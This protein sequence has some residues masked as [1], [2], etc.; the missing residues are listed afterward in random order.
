METQMETKNVRIKIAG[1]DDNCRIAAAYASW[2]YGGGITPEDTA[3]FA[4]ISGDVIGT[5][6]VAPEHGTLVLRGMQVAEQWR[7]LGIGIR[8]L[9]AVVSW[10][11][12]RRCYCIPFAHLERFYG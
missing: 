11:D 1:V 7:G 10:L 12:N 2:S 5:V 8:M 4:E 9:H 3:W 6:R